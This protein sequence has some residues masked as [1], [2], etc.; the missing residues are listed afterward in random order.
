METQPVDV[1]DA[2]TMKAQVGQLE[3][4]EKLLPAARWLKR[5]IQC[6]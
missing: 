1:G 5:K 6:V 4:D 3:S 2:Q